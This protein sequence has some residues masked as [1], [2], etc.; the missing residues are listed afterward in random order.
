MVVLLETG[1]NAIVGRD[2]VLGV[3]GGNKETGGGS[4]NEEEGG[5]NEAVGGRSKKNTKPYKVTETIRGMHYK[6][7]EHPCRRKLQGLPR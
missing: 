6:Y 1:D 7:T 4:E 2:V 3:G 5:G